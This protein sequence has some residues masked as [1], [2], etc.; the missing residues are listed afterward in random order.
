MAGVDVRSE[1][2]D[3]EPG[4]TLLGEYYAEVEARY[5][6]WSPDQGSAATVEEMSP[7]AG[8]FLVAYLDGAPVGCGTIRR[9]DD[10]TAEIK[11]MYV[12][13][14]ARG[15]GVARR[16]LAELEHAAREVGYARLVL[17]T[18]ERM[19]EAQA[20][21]RSSGYREMA[22]YNANPWATVCF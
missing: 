12:R 15:G 16:I 6:D 22:E 13:P 19:P 3:A 10:A 20:L 4:A 1:R 8:R 7:P 5:P 21:Y 2:A 11:R 14:G 9:L 18:G 17:D